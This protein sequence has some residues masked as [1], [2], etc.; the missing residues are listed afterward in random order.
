MKKAVMASFVTLI[1]GSMNPAFAAPVSVD[2]GQV[3]FVGSIVA[4]PCAV[5]TTSDGQ[6]VTLGQV[7]TNRLS[8]KGDSS[9]SVPF[10]IKLVGCDL[11]ADAIPETPDARAAYTSAS[12]T[13]I[14]ATA[15]DSQTL[16]VKSAATGAGDTTSAAQNVGIQ[17]LQNNE[18]LNVDG[19]AASE[20]QTIIA[21]ANEIPFSAKYVATA[22]GVVAGSANATVNFRVN[23]E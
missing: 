14:G 4:A 1:M 8:S 23:Y 3:N 15:G 12:I 10:S 7:P 11:G 18:P 17:I 20:S 19:S 16:A 6:T 13:F 5:D 21:G 2:G 9:S 22:D